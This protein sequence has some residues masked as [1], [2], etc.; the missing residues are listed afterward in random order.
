[1]ATRARDSRPAHSRRADEFNYLSGRHRV[2]VGGAAEA[3]LREIAER[4]RSQIAVPRGHRG[5]ATRLADVP[6][7]DQSLRLQRQSGSAENA[8]AARVRIEA[9]AGR[10]QPD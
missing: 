5:N 10:V 9:A 1:M 3:A 6:P 4:A 8:G 7:A 2:R